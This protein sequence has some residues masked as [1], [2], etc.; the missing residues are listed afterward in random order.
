[1]VNLK[2]SRLNLSTR[3]PLTFVWGNV[4]ALYASLNFFISS[5]SL[6]FISSL[7]IQISK[8]YHKTL[9]YFN[10]KE[11]NKN[12]K[13]IP[14]SLPSE[15]QEAKDDLNSIEKIKEFL[16]NLMRSLVEGAK[17]SKAV[18][19]RYAQEVSFSG[20]DGAFFLFRMLQQFASL[21]F[22]SDHLYWVSR[23]RYF[24][25]SFSLYHFLNFF[26]AVSILDLL[27]SAKDPRTIENSLKTFLKSTNSL[28]DVSKLTECFRAIK[29]DEDWLDSFKYV[30]LNSLFLHLFDVFVVSS[31]Y[32]LFPSPICAFFSCSNL[33]MI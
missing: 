33:E 28:N 20:L 23:L 21:K 1:M 2:A 9:L 15:S 3:I 25:S 22:I 24:S 17:A 5:V 13:T 26:L 18:F 7:I 29:L 4:E 32:V 16:K 11:L 6:S 19:G 31:P 10:I 8:G 12:L 27:S 30:Q 14:Q